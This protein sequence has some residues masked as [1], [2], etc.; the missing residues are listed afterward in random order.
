MF[1][2]CDTCRPPGSQHSSRAVSST[3]LG[4]IR[5]AQ[6]GGYHAAAHNV[7][8]DRPDALPTELSQLGNKILTFKLLLQTAHGLH[9]YCLASLSLPIYQL[10]FESC[11]A[12]VE[13]EFTT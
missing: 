10:Y 4:G 5:G 1:L 9:N 11:P 8:S 7:R 2:R 6:S 13:F 3:Y 12:E